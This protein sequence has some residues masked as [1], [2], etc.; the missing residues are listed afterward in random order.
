[1]AGRIA[2]AWLLTLPAAAVAGAIAGSVAGPGTGGVIT[3]AAAAV[4]FAAGL[5]GLSRRHRV[6]ADNV[7]QIDTPVVAPAG[8]AS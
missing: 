4:A 2:I 1:M 6:G 8:V 5:Y 7:N 3:V